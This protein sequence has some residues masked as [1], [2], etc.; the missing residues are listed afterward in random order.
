MQCIAFTFIRVD[1][2]RYPAEKPFVHLPEEY[3]PKSGN[4]DMM[5]S[6]AKEYTSKCQYQPLIKSVD[7]ILS[8]KC[9]TSLIIPYIYTNEIKICVFQGFETFVW[10]FDLTFPLFFQF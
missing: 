9:L 2:I 8:L 6:Y 3:R 7:G 1:Y 4:M 10:L 5:T